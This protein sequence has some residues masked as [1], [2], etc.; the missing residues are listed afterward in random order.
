MQSCPKCNKKHT[1]F[2]RA[3]YYEVHTDNVYCIIANLASLGNSEQKEFSKQARF[4]WDRMREYV[5]VNFPNDI[6]V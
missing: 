4:N 2:P 6:K 1:K 5:C 3:C